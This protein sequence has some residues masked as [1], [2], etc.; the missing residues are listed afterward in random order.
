MKHFSTLQRDLLAAA[1]ASADRQVAIPPGVGVANG[2]AT[3]AALVRHGLVAVVHGED[4]SRR[5]QITELGA[6]AVLRPTEAPRPRERRRKVR[7]QRIGAGLAAPGDRFA[8]DDTV[9]VNPKVKGKSAKM[10]ELLTRPDG[11]TMDELVALTGWKRKSVLGT[12]HGAFK[13]RLR[14]NVQRIGSFGESR[15]IAREMAEG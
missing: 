3:V 14:L 9:W 8:E 12:L 13:K 5:L 2:G 6:Q 10:I 1:L 4:G 11:A 7:G 15:W